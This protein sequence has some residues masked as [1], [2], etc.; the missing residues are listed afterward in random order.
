MRT[1]LD[2]L[3]ALL[4]TL[5]WTVY[6]VDV[7]EAPT[8]P[9]MLLNPPVGNFDRLTLCNGVDTINDLFDVICAGESP[10]AVLEVVGRVH[11]LLVDATPSIEGFRVDPIRHVDT[12]PVA[13]DREARLR[14][15]FVMF[16]TARFRYS[17]NPA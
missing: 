8:Y 15:G 10:E 12:R 16:S 3:K 17:A 14:H 9:Y 11:A 5:P 6:V 1:H 7:P 2:A 13:E 4:G